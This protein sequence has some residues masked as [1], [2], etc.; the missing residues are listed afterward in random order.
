MLS[1]LVYQVMNLAVTIAVPAASYFGIRFLNDRVKD[2]RERLKRELHEH[3]LQQEQQQIQLKQQKR[4]QND[5][6][7]LT[8][9]EQA[10]KFSEQ[11][12]KHSKNAENLHRLKLDAA[13][14][15][16]VRNSSSAGLQVDNDVARDKIE[17]VI[18]DLN[19]QH[20]EES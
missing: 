11:Q 15:Y 20:H 17:V 4:Q 8:I 6:W 16:I 9:A 3:E 10:V 1:Y 5:E 2:Q 7:L 13:I 14:D 19:E 12:Y 18:H